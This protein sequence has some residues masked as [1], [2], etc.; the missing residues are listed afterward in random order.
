VNKQKQQ[1]ETISSLKA[2]VTLLLFFV[3]ISIATK[4]FAENLTSTNFQV[5]NPTFMLEG[6]QASSTNFQYFSNTGEFSI[7]EALSTNF[8]NRLGFLYFPVATSP[9]VSATPGSGQVSLSWTA[10]TGTLANVSSYEV[11]VST[12]ASGTYTYTSVGNVLTSVKTGLT[13]STTYY[14]KI[15]SY[16]A[17]ILLSESS[18]V[19]ATPVGA[20]GGGGSGGS[21][22][23]G[24]G[25]GSGGSN[26]TPGSGIGGVVFS[27]KAYPS[28]TV[29]LLKDAQVVTSTI[30]GADANF[31]ISVSDISGGN[32]IFSIYSEDSQGNRSS[33][34]T[35]PVSVT[36]GVVSNVS[37]I[38]IAPT[39]AV[40]KSEVKKGENIAI[41]GQSVPNAEV[42]ISVHSSEEIF[43]KVSS[44]ANGTY[45]MN[46]DTSVLELGDHV[47][48]SKAAKSTEITAFGKTVGFIVGNK[49]VLASKDNKCPAKADLNGD[50]K[51][52]LVDYSIAAY[53]YK[54]SLNDTTATLEKSKLNGDGKID[55]VDFSIIA[56]YWTG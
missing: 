34:L 19:S 6:G 53:W 3:F 4:S 27:G 49:T 23:G 50:C 8:T 12:S 7:G 32:Y 25:G 21:S 43:K 39:I 28:R 47:T 52:N 20:S 41:F 48:K 30:A 11:G 17:G 24:G 2:I 13:N 29:V 1:Q 5:E 55:L 37:G 35:F 26:P 45:L 14:F 36:N 46:F 16:A 38:F 44:D 56:Y 54:R 15:R 42:T 22:G 33:L 10:A 18:A 31:S 40:D 51:V 9:I